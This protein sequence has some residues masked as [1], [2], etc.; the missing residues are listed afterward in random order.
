MKPSHHAPPSAYSVTEEPLAPRWGSWD[1][2]L[3]AR[4][5]IRS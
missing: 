2:S 5:L 4:I 3:L 1:N